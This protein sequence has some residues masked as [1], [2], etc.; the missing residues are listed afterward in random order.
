M[1]RNERVW[2]ALLVKI[3]NAPQAQRS[4]ACDVLWRTAMAA[5][6]RV[7]L[8][9]IALMLFSLDGVARHVPGDAGDLLWSRARTRPCL[10]CGRSPCGV[11][12][13]ES[14]TAN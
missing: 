14:R 3:I 1:T 11:W 12:C 4:E 10:R 9:S 7:E 13:T 6:G 2:G 8:E 5:E